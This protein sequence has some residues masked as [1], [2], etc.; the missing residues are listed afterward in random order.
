MGFFNGR[1]EVKTTI[2]K[3]N[4]EAFHAKQ[5]A[6]RAQQDAT[7]KAA[8]SNSTAPVSP[9]PVAQAKETYSPQQPTEQTP[10][11]TQETP[12]ETQEATPADVSTANAD[13]KEE[14]IDVIKDYDWT[15]S[16]NKQQ[17]QEKIPF[18]RLKE[19]RITADNAINALATSVFAWSDMQK[20]GANAVGKMGSIAGAG[21][22][23]AA[24]AAGLDQELDWIKNFKDNKVAK[25][26]TSKVGALGDSIE[27][28][29][30]MAKTHASKAQS[31]SDFGPE[32][33]HLMDVYGGLY[34]REST[35]RTYT[36]PY[37]ENEYFST[38]NTFSDTTTIP[39]IGQVFDKI[40][41]ASQG[42]AALVEPGVYVQRPKYYNFASEGN[43]FSFA[44]TL[45]NTI[46][47]MA[48]L[49]NSQLIQQL[50]LNNLPRR[51]TKV[52]VEPPCIYEVLIPG[53]AFFPYCFITDLRVMHVGTK[54]L[55][56][57]EIVPDAFEVQIT[58]K[59]LTTD[60]NNF[61]EKQMQH[62]EMTFP[63][64]QDVSSRGDA[65]ATPAGDGASNGQS[66]AQREAIAQP[67]AAQLTPQDINAATP[68]GTTT[69]SENMDELAERARQMADANSPLIR[70]QDRDG[71]HCWA[72]VKTA[73]VK[74]GMVGQYPGSVH[75]Y[76]AGS[77]LERNGFTRMNITDP[78]QAPNGAVIVYGRT[79]T[80]TSGHIEIKS[81]DK[82]GQTRWVSDVSRNN[83]SSSM[84]V[85]G[86]YVKK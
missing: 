6:E 26:I 37:Y 82:R 3:G 2:G 19:Y 72:G 63:T 10:P 68:P 84:P 24:S 44:I 29:I 38:N 17:L 8:M 76:Q 31:P 56:D 32:G 61:Y 49:K 86:I 20:A 21:I 70:G 7:Y 47:P 30:E 65:T 39:L 81:T 45:Y 36:F 64:A 43:Q 34:A 25:V 35:G 51:K 67:A 55:M 54:R 57:G 22:T 13:A 48:H 15:A 14:A 69:T 4:L 73:L 80:H 77:D 16:I 83:P 60:A 71:A 41:E 23:D 74:S 42:L 9:A 28:Y 62:H 27:R 59:S 85:A 18:I 12:Q 53:K 50:I 58:I 1:A 79:A 78:R 52:V 46:T 33:Q 11:P 66:G 5:A 75:A 40:N